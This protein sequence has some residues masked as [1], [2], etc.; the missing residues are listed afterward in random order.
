MLLT[1]DARFAQRYKSLPQ[2]IRVLTEHW[3]ESN[4]YCPNCGNANITSFPNN[5]PV[6]DYFC[7][8]CSE[9]YELK[10][11]KSV[12][13]KIVDGAYQTM[14]ERLGSNN[15]PSLFFLNYEP[16][17][18]MVANFFI[19]PKHLFVPQIIEKRKPL[20][21]SARRAGWVGCNILLNAIPKA[22]KIFYIKSGAARPKV[23][24]LTDWQ[25]SLFLKETK[26]PASKGW[27]LDIMLC[28]DDIGRKDFSLNDM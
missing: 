23:N 26:A 28:I 4:I 22:G 13:R 10:S 9:E 24:V 2:K 16:S 14:I 18:L 15:N 17:K 25:R 19:I 11:S 21:P 3:V 1:M 27:L 12:G 20:A 5:K 7:G 6:A 8:N